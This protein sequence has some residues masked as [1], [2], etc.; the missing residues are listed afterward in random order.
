MTSPQEGIVANIRMR[1]AGSVITAGEAILDIVPENEVV[2]VE[3]KVYS[4]HRRCPR[5]LEH[6]RSADRIQ[7]EAVAPA[8]GE[9][10]LCRAGPA[11]R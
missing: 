8:A 3:A 6:P 11:R 5:R 2:I 10:R 9:G 4:R 7:F 1:T